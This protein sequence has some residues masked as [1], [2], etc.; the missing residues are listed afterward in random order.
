MVLCWWRLGG[1]PCWPEAE[2]PPHWAEPPD[3]AAD[4]CPLFSLFA[5]DIASWVGLAGWSL[6]CI[7]A[8]CWD[9]CSASFSG[10]SV[11]EVHV[12]L[13]PSTL[14][15]VA[16]TSL[17]MF[18]HGNSNSG[19]L[20]MPI[21]YAKLRQMAASKTG[22]A[23]FSNKSRKREKEGKMPNTKLAVKQP[24]A[25]KLCCSETW[26]KQKLQW[27]S[28]ATIA[29]KPRSCSCSCSC[30]CAAENLSHYTT[31]SPEASQET[32]QPEICSRL[33][34]QEVVKLLKSCRWPIGVRDQHPTPVAS[35][36][37]SLKLLHLLQ[38]GAL[39]VHKN[40]RP[41]TADF[42]CLRCGTARERWPVTGRIRSE[43]PVDC[44]S[45]PISTFAHCASW[46]CHQSRWIAAF[47]RCARWCCWMRWNFPFALC[48]RWCCCPIGWTSLHNTSRV[49][50]APAFHPCRS[51]RRRSIR[52]PWHWCHWRRCQPRTRRRSWL[53]IT[54]RPVPHVSLLWDPNPPPLTPSTRCRWWWLRW[55]RRC[56]TKF[57]CCSKIDCWRR[58]AVVPAHLAGPPRVAPSSA[59]SSNSW[60]GTVTSMIRHAVAPM[61]AKDGKIVAQARVKDWRCQ[62]KNNSVI[63]AIEVLDFLPICSV[64]Q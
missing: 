44:R 18:W 28:L 8:A 27:N 62:W 10:E 45:R 20:S 7:I 5:K 11:D 61:A 49:P 48:A 17:F 15:G 21:S 34:L 43:L 35:G 33:F 24:V 16:G 26:N 6:M 53:R 2:F 50:W 29:V 22:S 32:G 40:G 64:F 59:T 37:T 55:L 38:E 54:S 58:T 3:A 41:H 56:P 4:P 23:N 13:G 60:S 39:V 47:A 30:V 9:C 51:F 31:P 52:T 25:V 36:S 1:T 14:N 57:L 19:N 63:Y 46:C 12:L 42:F